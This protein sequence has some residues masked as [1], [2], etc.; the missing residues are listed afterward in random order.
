VSNGNGS[1]S[2]DR[3]FF[4]SYAHTAPLAG[5]EPEPADYWVQMVFEDLS[6]AVRGA[7]GL[8]P[9]TQVG[10]F[11]GLLGAGADWKSQ[12]TRE[13]AAAQVFVPLCAP[14]Y[15]AMSWPG[16]EWACYATRL[17]DEPTD[18]P[19]P[20]IVPA[21][22][23][24]MS[25]PAGPA[26]APNPLLHFEDIPEYAENG[27]R[28]LK[29]LSLY[30][31][32]YQ[33]VIS[34]LARQIVDVAHTAP[35][36]AGP[37]PQLDEVSSAFRFKGIEDD[38]VIAVAA[39]TRSTVSPDRA[40]SWYGDKSTDWRPFGEHEQMRLADHAL[41]AAERLSFTTAV[42]GVGA[43]SEAVTGTPVIVLIDP[44]IAETAGQDTA[45]LDGLRRLYAD[46]RERRW[47]LPLVV[48]NEDDPESATCRTALIERLLCILGE[49]GAPLMEGSQGRNTV[50]TSIDDFARA[51][52][53][54]VAEAER[55]YLRYNPLF[56]DAATGVRRPVLGG[57]FADSDDDEWER[58]DDRDA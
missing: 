55:R 51:M 6:E 35:L 26:N 1:Q 46:S 42:V 17:A 5:S 19:S 20:H 52:P 25:W 8:S 15:F 53:V 43:V 18:E 49:M 33:S 54:L 30:G 47:V 23:A 36:A 21:L 10:F 24:P 41:N 22:W 40:V 2:L 29:I 58:P 39:P 9:G 37:V 16:R 44:W 11:D 14:R 32:Q 56:P 27:L 12:T 45:A 38:F 7:A 31:G 34:R 28:V 4:L 48:L 3:Y 57:S 50:V 13:L